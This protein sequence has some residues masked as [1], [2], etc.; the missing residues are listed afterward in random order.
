M[1]STGPAP[2]FAISTNSSDA[3]DPPV[4][5][6][7]TTRVETGQ[8]HRGREGDASPERVGGRRQARQAQGDDESERDIRRAPDALHA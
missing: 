8:A 5:T 3:L 7:D 1:R 4:W 2:W 6:S